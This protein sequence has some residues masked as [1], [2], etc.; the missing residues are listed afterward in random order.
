MKEKKKKKKASVGRSYTQAIAYESFHKIK[1]F[2]KDFLEPPL[3]TSNS[4]RVWG[5]KNYLQYFSR[6]H[7]VLL[8]N[9]S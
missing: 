3:N 5:I 6:V 7:C 2:T 4:L 8:R 1:N 9:I